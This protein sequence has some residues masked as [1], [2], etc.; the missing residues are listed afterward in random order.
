MKFKAEFDS[1]DTADI[2][3]AALRNRISSISSI[4]VK[5][6]SPE[7][8]KRGIRILPAFDASTTTTPMFSLPI[9]N[10]AFVNS[11][12]SST[13]EADYTRKHP[14]LEVVCRKEDEKT[15][16]NIIVGYGG[17]NIKKL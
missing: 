4:Q 12:I 1:P 7:Q 16:S 5:D 2:C 10:A 6:T 8:T 15:V 13:V 9:F 17:L 11:N 3:A 14:T